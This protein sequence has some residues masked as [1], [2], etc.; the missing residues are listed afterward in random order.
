MH[1]L[2]EAVAAA[3]PAIVTS[4]DN[5]QDFKKDVAEL[6]WHVVDHDA[7][8]TAETHGVWYPLIIDSYILSSGI[9]VVG[10]D[11]STM[12]LLAEYR[13]RDWHAGSFRKVKWGGKDAD[14]HRRNIV[15]DWVADE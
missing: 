12:S 1:Q 6:G 13:V 5:S 2:S 14:A 10:T 11:G 4:D 8:G 3:L 7:L 9:G 15:E